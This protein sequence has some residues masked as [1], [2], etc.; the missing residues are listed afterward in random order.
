MLVEPETCFEPKLVQIDF[1]RQD[2]SNVFYELSDGTSFSFYE[3][4]P[5]WQ[6]DDIVTDEETSSWA[7]LSQALE[8][9]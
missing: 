8:C 7:N 6:V 2:G 4:C 9:K 5:G 1:I 3:G